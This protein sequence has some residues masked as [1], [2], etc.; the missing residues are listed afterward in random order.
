MQ[1]VDRVQVVVLVVPAEGAARRT[2]MDKIRVAWVV[3]GDSEGRN[4]MVGIWEGGE[5]GREGREDR[6]FRRVFSSFRTVSNTT[7]IYKRS[8]RYARS[9]QLSVL[10]H[11]SGGGGSRRKRRIFC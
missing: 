2:C 9:A 6:I 11:F 4:D 5:G 7:G 8:L 3:F 10:R 1:V